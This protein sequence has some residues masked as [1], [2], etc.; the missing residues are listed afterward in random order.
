LN[1][2]I[3]KLKQYLSDTDYVVIKIAEGAATEEDYAEVILQREAARA[4][5][6]E[7]ESQIEELKKQLDETN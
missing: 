7:L 2:Q 4:S 1:S 6:N 5:I 3:A